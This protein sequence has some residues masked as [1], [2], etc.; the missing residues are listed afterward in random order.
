MDWLLVAGDGLG[1]CAGKLLLAVEGVELPLEDGGQFT[2][3]RLRSGTD[4]RNLMGNAGEA[5][6]AGSKTLGIP[7]FTQ[8]ADEGEPDRAE[9]H[10]E[11]EVGGGGVEGT[12]QASP[13]NGVETSRFPDVGGSDTAAGWFGEAEGTNW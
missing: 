2:G 10:V 12:A 3:A 7:F 1:Q 9:F 6:D 11:G 13:K 4:G 5:G 8:Q